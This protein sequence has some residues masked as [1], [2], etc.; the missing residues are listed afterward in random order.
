MRKEKEKEGKSG[1]WRRPGRLAEIQNQMK[2]QDHVTPGT[3]SVIA[4]PQQP[5]NGPGRQATIK[6][7][8]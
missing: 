8:Q 4:G 6:I 2:P 1:E 3:G 5:T 7:K